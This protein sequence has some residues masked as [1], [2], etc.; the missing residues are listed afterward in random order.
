MLTC[1]CL[2]LYT[3]HSYLGFY[4]S[5]IVSVQPYNNFRVFSHLQ[6]WKYSGK[7]SHFPATPHTTGKWSSGVWTYIKTISYTS[8]ILLLLSVW[9]HIPGNTCGDLMWYI[10]WLI[11]VQ[12]RAYKTVIHIVKKWHVPFQLSYRPLDCRKEKVLGAQMCF[13]AF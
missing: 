1:E 9:T 2:C 3:R 6:I 10:R 5:F 12:A 13:I 7:W 4:L 11:V 8:N